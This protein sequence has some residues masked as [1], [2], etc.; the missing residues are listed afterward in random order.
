MNTC[1]YVRYGPAPAPIAA[2]YKVAQTLSW[3]SET[4]FRAA[5]Y[6]GESHLLP[7]KIFR[8][9]IRRLL[10]TLATI[11]NKPIT[12]PNGQ[13]DILLH[14]GPFV[15]NT[16]RST[17]CGLALGFAICSHGHAGVGVNKSFNPNSAVSTPPSALT[18]VMLN[19]NGAAATAVALTDTLPAGFVGVARDPEVLANSSQLN[20]I[21]A[22]GL[23]TAE[24]ATSPGCKP[25][26]ALRTG[27]A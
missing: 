14:L 27:A 10:T 17:F 8:L 2:H 16:L 3:V 13:R 6:G 18:I 11:A 19:P 25:A 4:T 24:G 23:T 22:G 21:A 15:L 20:T 5:D 26:R 12:D 9:E 1:R 7:T